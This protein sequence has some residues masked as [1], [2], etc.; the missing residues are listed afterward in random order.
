M[1]VPF[2]A[3]ASGTATTSAETRETDGGTNSAT[4]GSANA[5]SSA[6]A[7]TTSATTAA[8]TTGEDTKK[9]AACQTT[10]AGPTTAVDDATSSSSNNGN[11]Q[12]RQHLELRP[13]TEYYRCCNHRLY[14]NNRGSGDSTARIWDMSDT[15]NSPN[16]L[17]LRHCVQKGGA[18][19]PSNKDVR[20]LDWNCDGTLL[21]TVSY[22]GFARI[23]KTDGHLAS[24]L[25]QHKRP[26]FALK[27]NKRGN[28]ILSA[29]VDKTT[30]RSVL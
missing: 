26:I 27:W 22:D 25:G 16:Q 30:I 29:G 5:S 4:A 2:G 1:E 7:S 15:G 14:A 23:W 6:A 9:P 8:T 18:E 10:A 11:L 28:Y 19:V 17:V 21:A 3:T 13:S 24:T 20:S 12:V